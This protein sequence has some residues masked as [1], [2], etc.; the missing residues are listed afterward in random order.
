[1]RPACEGF[2]RTERNSKMRPISETRDI[3]RH[4]K[5]LNSLVFLIKKQW[6]LRAFEQ[7]CYKYEWQTKRLDWN[8]TLRDHEQYINFFEAII[9]DTFRCI[10][11]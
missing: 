9:N 2:H 8:T 10:L 4:N 3:L 11:F 6:L 1:M 5:F 7:L